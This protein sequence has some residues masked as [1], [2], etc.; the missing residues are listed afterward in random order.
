MANEL[1]VVIKGDTHD[2]VSKVGGLNKALG[3]LGDVAGTAVKVGVVGAV[4]G[5]G[6][7]AAGLGVSV[8]A[9]MDAQEGQA[10]LASVLASTGGKAG[11]TAKMANDLASALQNTT[12][13]EDDT[14]LAGENMLLTFT[15]IGKDVF[16]QATE[17]MLDMSQALGQDVKAS[18]IQ[19]GKALN[20]PIQGVTALRRVG[21]SF[22]DAQMDQIKALQE[23]GALMGAQKMI[24]KELQTEFGG[25]AKAAG[26]TFA[27]KMDILQ[28][29]FGDVQEMIG[30][31]LIP[32]LSTAADALIGFLNNDAV[33]N[34]ATQIG[35]LFAVIASGDDLASGVWEIFDNLFGPD[36]ADA[37]AGFVGFIEGDVIPA[38]KALVG[39]VAENIPKVASLIGS[40]F[41]AGKDAG[42]GFAQEF[43]KIQQAIL[44]VWNAIQPI[45]Q[46]I[47][48]TLAQFWT[49][50][51][52]K[53]A[54]A[55]ETIQTII[56]TVM[57][58]VGTFIREHMTEITAVMRAAW[59]AISGI[60]QIA[61]ALISGIVK[62]ALD[63]L[64]G[65]FDAAGR[66]WK[67]TFLAV[68]E[69]LKK[70]FSAA[71]EIIKV[72]IGGALNAIWQAIQGKMDD[73]RQTIQNK[74][75]EIVNWFAS[76]PERLKQAGIDI[77]Q[78]LIDGF[79]AQ[80]D[81]VTQALAD[82]V[83]QAVQNIMNLLGM[84][85]PSRVMRDMGE[86]MAKGLVMGWG[87][88]ALSLNV[89]SDRGLAGAAVPAAPVGAETGGG[90]TFIINFYGTSA[91][92]NRAE[93]TVSAG[94]FL[95]GLRAKGVQI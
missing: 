52:P 32:I 6:A 91:P 23:S 75:D 19:L 84:H 77:L 27:G 25:A 60:V 11:V 68:W 33:Q 92:S 29:K 48:D 13:F 17:T 50:I 71:W 58:A 70:I 7:L 83:N 8:K 76:L 63:L 62:I 41:Q 59:D 22:T 69:G 88:P 44:T 74:W 95:D 93:A 61:W 10:Q 40:L 1:V 67:E 3:G 4:A 53:L 24:L 55:W 26:E 66:D 82:I 39:F 81:A 86:N 42:G 90:N 73:V 45:L 87:T 9:A 54:K 35:N 12:R 64:G 85:S 72:I 49:E 36:V 21:V 18:A 34:F 65:D 47:F 15:N 57:A 89:A 30:N 46:A 16:P 51:Q 56:N 28:H 94:L 5:I 2:A 78:G 20:D 43:P 37:V 38:V 31:A 14:T 80:A 79:W